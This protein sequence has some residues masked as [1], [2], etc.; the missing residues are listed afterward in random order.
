MQPFCAAADWGTSSFR[1]WLISEDGRAVAERRSDEGMTHAAKAGFAH[2]LEA[3]LGALDAPKNL[4]VV[5][6]GMAG[7]RQGWQEA[8][9]LTVPAAL[10][11]IVERAVAVEGLDR[12]VRILPGFAQRDP[13]HPDVM[14]GEE[15]QLLGSFTGRRLSGLACMP[16]THS[17]WV[18]VEDRCV[19]G[20]STFMTGEL[21]SLI[22]RHSILRHAVGQ[23][24]NCRADSKDF[25]SG[26]AE[27][28]ADPATISQLLF[29]IRAGQLL[30]GREA[31]SSFERLSGLLIGSE[32]AAGLSQF[33]AGRPIHL[34]ASGKLFALYRSAF[35]ALG[36]EIVAIDADEAVL[37]GLLAGARRYWPSN[38]HADYGQLKA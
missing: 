25:L 21:F 19:T 38:H 23:A 6:C 12:D 27:A 22:T 3:H 37:T 26:V 2:V 20:F 10:S 36:H 9:Y 31:T 4:P 13:S 16:G 35:Q 28:H 30:Y 7:S 33:S 8:R 32:I 24:E 34:I 11:E 1:I 14:R 5:I 15:T 29:T 17:K 18:S